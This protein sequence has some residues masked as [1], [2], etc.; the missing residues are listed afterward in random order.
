MPVP[1]NAAAV[2]DSGKI[3]SRTLTRQVATEFSRQNIFPTTEMV[4]KRI[5]EI[6]E[7][8]IKPSATTVQDEMGKWYAEVFWP[9][10]HALGALPEDPNV[11]VEIRRIFTD[12]FRLMT[13]EVFGAAS[14]AW[15]TER[16]E[17][18]LQINEADKTVER[19]KDS[20]DRAAAEATAL[21]AQL[22]DEVAAHQ[23]TQAR[24][25]DLQQQVTQQAAQLQQAA[26][27]EVD[28]AR[29]INDVRAEERRRQDAAEAAA[30]E[31]RNRL[32]KQID[33]LRQLAKGQ[34]QQIGHLHKQGENLT[35]LLATK[36]TEISTMER[37]HA[38]EVGRLNRL[39]EAERARASKLAT[40]LAA[41]NKPGARAAA[42]KKIA[43][44]TGAR[45]RTTLHKQRLPA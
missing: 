7:G 28:H 34:E 43:R 9:S 5:G 37:K 15:D 2:E 22:A 20:A 29:Q 36:Q 8:R 41:T 21:K 13:V 38:D 6:T 16:A 32:M 30:T 11:P 26:Q 45:S 10:Y 4:R 3:S 12:T 23:R 44:A 17:Y 14:R 42:G 25:E 1:A 39:A 40:E 35:L 27:R 33:E 19:L 18:Q 31:E 24:A